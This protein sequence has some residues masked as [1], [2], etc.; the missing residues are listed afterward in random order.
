MQQRILCVC[1]RSLRELCQRHVRDHLYRMSAL[2]QRGLCVHLWT[3]CI[4]CQRHL[5]H[6]LQRLPALRH[7]PESGRRLRVGLRSLLDLQ[8]ERHLHVQ[9]QWLRALQY[10]P[11]PGRHVCQRVRPMRDVHEWSV[12]RMRSLPVPDLP[13]W[14]LYV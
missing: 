3:L 2:P 13:G 4:L 6:H 8:P 5:R 1:L 11:E 7:Q 10:Q 12:C 9:L 14:R